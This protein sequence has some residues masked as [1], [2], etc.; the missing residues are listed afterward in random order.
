MFEDLYQT[1]KQRYGAGS[2]KQS[3]SEWVCNNTTIK[4][5]TPFSFDGYEF[6][7]AI[8]DDMHP[9]LSCIKC[10]Q[11]GLTEV[12]LRKYL[13]T[14]TRYDAVSG[15]FS[16]PN[17]DMFK[18]VYK[19]RLK[20]I[21]DRDDIFNPPMDVKPIRSTGLIQIRESFGYITGCGEDDATSI[22]AD[23]LMHDELDLSPEDMIG[24]YQSR[25]QNSN[26]RITQKFSTPTFKGYGIDKDYKLTDQREYEIRC[27]ACNHWQIPLFNRKF[28]HCP[29]FDQL[30]LKEFTD[31]TP[32]I[33]AT[34]DLSETYVHCERCCK[35]LDLANPELREWVARHPSRTAFRGYYVRPFSAGRLS[36]QYVFT[37]LAKYQKVGFTR[38]FFNTVL[39]EPHNSAD[40][41][42]QREDVE[43]CMIS[44][45][46]ANVSYGTPVFM[47]IDVGFQCYITLS[48][49][50][51]KGTPHWVLFEQVPIAR[52][53]ARIA[54]LRKVYNI[55][56]AGIDRFPFT[57]TVDALRD[58][59]QGLVM[60]I[61]WRGEKGLIPQKD[62]LGV[63]TH[64]SANPTQT[65]DRMLAAISQRKMVIGGY[66]H[67][68]ETLITHLCDMVRDESPDANAEATWKKTSGNDHYFHSMAFN[69]LSR[70]I[71]EHMYQTQSGV[72]ATSSTISGATIGAQD[73]LPGHHA[74][75][76]DRLGLT[77]Q[78]GDVI[79][80]HR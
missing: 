15:I 30:N 23:F 26:M 27:S 11:V 64:Y 4:R 62:E 13:A 32:E 59:T 12:Q 17:E 74:S 72:T 22:P 56:G 66:T 46:I 61:Q 76:S 52:L 3:N 5:A 80:R 67:S 60:P 44:G 21:L 9:D 78:R 50:D 18:R 2:S 14:L 38:G 8:M 29:E 1:V 36:P 55:V 37:Q 57:P 19:T 10:S 31:L 25:L 63:L 40:S 45:E 69:L 42:V 24:L 49:D 65:F 35:P 41:Q 39:G 47:G 51:E 33:I 71:C 16:L 73:N 54:E 20:P 68:R 7:R 6:Q 79:T 58:F 53:E 48:F 70:R 34:M 75:T 77:R 28:V 43:A